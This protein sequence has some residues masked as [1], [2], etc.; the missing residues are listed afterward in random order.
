MLGS[1]LRCVYERKGWQGR[2]KVS[3]QDSLSTV[4][5]APGAEGSADILSALSAQRELSRKGIVIAGRLRPLA[6]SM[7]RSAALIASGSLMQLADSAGIA[8]RRHAKQGVAPRGQPAIE[9]RSQPRERPERKNGRPPFP[10]G[11]YT[12]DFNPGEVTL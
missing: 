10:T 1:A 7:S 12:N 4:R 6:D 11:Q 8:R 9:D 2:A 5:S 3:D